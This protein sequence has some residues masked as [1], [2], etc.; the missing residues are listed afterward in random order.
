MNRSHTFKSLCYLFAPICTGAFAAGSL[1]LAVDYALPEALAQYS[2]LLTILA[3]IGV[4]FYLLTS[5]PCTVLAAWHSIFAMIRD[6]KYLFPGI[7]LTA[8]LALIFCWIQAV[9]MFS[10]KG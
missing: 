8:D 2:V 9:R 10:L 3:V 7:F 1:Y 5:L 6:K 4:G